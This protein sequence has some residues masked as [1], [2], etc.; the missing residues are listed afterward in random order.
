MSQRV[1]I[2][3]SVELEK[4][5]EA[6]G[7][8]INKIYNSDYRSLT[9]DFDQLLSYLNK[10]N[11]KQAVKLIDDIRKKLMNIDLCLGDSYSILSAYQ[12][13]LLEVKE[14]KEGA[15]GS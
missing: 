1:N 5:P 8:L 2:T 15:D 14:E 4:V 7:D 12:R 3:Y 6:V 9:K 13:H 10:Q 11:E